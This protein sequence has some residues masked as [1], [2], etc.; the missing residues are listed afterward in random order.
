MIHRLGRLE[1]A[2]AL[3]EEVYRSDPSNT[4]VYSLLGNNLCK[5]KRW[6]EASPVLEAAL[7][8]GADLNTRYNYAVCLLNTDKR[9]EAKDAFEQVLEETVGEKCSNEKVNRKRD[10][11]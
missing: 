3:F 10:Q 2:T 5:L 1:E 6:A 11:V 7:A 4:Q 8:E 9:P